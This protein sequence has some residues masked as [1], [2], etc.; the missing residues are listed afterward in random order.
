MFGFSGA[1]PI[2]LAHVS[3]RGS[4]ECR[5]GL[6]SRFE[7]PPLAFVFSGC[8]IG[9]WGVGLFRVLFFVL[10][11][12]KRTAFAQFSVPSGSCCLSFA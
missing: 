4:A 6:D 9:I 10:Y 11:Q 5:T 3:V 12:G 7:V 8:P 1:S 2:T